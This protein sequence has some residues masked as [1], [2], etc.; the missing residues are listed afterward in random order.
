MA[1]KPRHELKYFISAADARVLA[2]HLASVLRRDIHAGENGEYSIRSLYFDDFRNSAYRDKVDGAPERAKYRLRI[3]NGS[4]EV[5]FLEKKKKMG[6]LIRKSD[7]RITRRLAE[8]LIDGNPAGLA[9]SQS[10][11]LR[12]MFVQMRVNLL[13]AK[14]IVDYEREAFTF[15]AE[16]VRITL[17]KRVRSGL[18]CVDLFDPQIAT[19]PVYPASQTVLEVKYDRVLPDFLPP[20]LSLIPAQRSAISKYTACRAL[21]V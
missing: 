12:D 8:Q 2:R 14:V 13:R 20:I 1:E 18:A 4:D 7:V 5:I 19:V 11:L 10:P 16:N 3:Y 6:D 17:D 9:A 21:S 15:P